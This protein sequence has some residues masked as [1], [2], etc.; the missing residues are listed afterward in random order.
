MSS[1]VDWDGLAAALAGSLVRPDDPEFAGLRRAFVSGLQEHL[2]AAVARCASVP[3]VAQAVKFAHAHRLPFALRSGGHSFADHCATEGLL[4]DLAALDSVQVQGGSVTA[5]PGVRLGPLARQLADCGQIISVGWNPLV[6]VGGAVLGGGYGSLGRSLGLGCDQLAAAQ[7]VL[8]DGA[9][10]WVDDQREP[11]LY[12]ALRGAGWAGFAVVTALVLRT[13]PSQQLTTFVHHW[14]WAQA[15]AV[16]DT[17]QRWAPAAPDRVNM[18]LV[19]QS[20][21]ATADP[22]LTTF[23]TVLAPAAQARELVAEFVHAVDP[24]Q[25]LDELTELSSR[26][27]PV[28]HTYA[29]MP[30]LEKPPPALPMGVSPFMRAVK[31]EFFDAPIPGEAIEAL[32]DTFVTDRVPTAYCELEFIP[33]RGAFAQV[34][35]EATAFAHRGCQ[36]QIGHHGMVA[37]QAGTA[38]RQA[39]REWVRRSWRSVH[40]WGAGKVYPNYPDPELDDWAEAYFGANLARLRQVKGRYD[41]TD[42]FHFAQSIPPPPTPPS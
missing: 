2:P 34:A 25:E 21:D 22:R 9:A 19:I 41:P 38:E 11:D 5:G 42:V 37:N 28:R 32:L 36:F 40:A 1:P 26:A 23:G 20:M 13:R 12:W 4:I 3:D 7:V 16:I 33:W 8:A 31:S 15:A 17:W 30:V 24:Q 14:P 39:A 29:G 27:A 18:E 6:A 35:P 10:V